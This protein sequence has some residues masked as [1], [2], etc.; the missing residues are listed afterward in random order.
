LS[1]AGKLGYW[2]REI[3]KGTGPTSGGWETVVPKMTGSNI[4]R[5]LKDS[6]HH[7]GIDRHMKFKSHTHMENCKIFF[8]TLRN[9][10][11]SPSSDIYYVPIF[12]FA[13][14]ISRMK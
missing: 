11:A 10:F 12:P 1:S 3:R 4:Y 2:Y 5:I 7:P 13:L 8:V 9:V 14:V 6:D